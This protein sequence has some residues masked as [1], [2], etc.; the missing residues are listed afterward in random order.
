MD[1]IEFPMHRIK[2]VRERERERE[3]MS[4]NIPVVASINIPVVAFPGLKNK[5]IGGIHS[6]WKILLVWKYEQQCIP[7]CS[8]GIQQE[9]YYAQE[10]FQQNLDIVGN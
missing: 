5:F 1:I 8:L 4:I 7:Q 6:I 3:R 2:Y 10:N 9:L